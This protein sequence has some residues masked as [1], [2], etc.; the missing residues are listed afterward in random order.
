MQGHVYIAHKLIQDMVHQIDIKV[1]Y[2]QSTQQNKN[3][4]T[5][6]KFFNLLFYMRDN[7]TFWA[8]DI[9]R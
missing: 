4:K 3:T 9:T 6:E 5:R 8:L 7:T 1:K 2:K